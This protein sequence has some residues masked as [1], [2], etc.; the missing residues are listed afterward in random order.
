[1]HSYFAALRIRPA[2]REICKTTAGTELPGRR[3]L[4]E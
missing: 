3:L 2:G 1:M 4:A